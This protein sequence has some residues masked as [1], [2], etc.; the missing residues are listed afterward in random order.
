MCIPGHPGTQY[1]DRAGFELTEIH[2]PLHQPY[3]AEDFILFF[4]TF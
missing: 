3:P 2:L 1:A 4:N